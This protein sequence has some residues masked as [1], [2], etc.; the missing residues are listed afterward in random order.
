[1]EDGEIRKGVPT[2]NNH[3]NSKKQIE[4]VLELK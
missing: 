3:L 4:G 2:K 1:V